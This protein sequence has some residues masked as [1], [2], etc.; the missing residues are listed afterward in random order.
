MRKVACMVHAGV[1][2]PDLRSLLGSLL[3]VVTSSR[4]SALARVFLA[5]LAFGL[6]GPLCPGVISGSVCCSCA[7]LFLHKGVGQ[8]LAPCVFIVSALVQLRAQGAQSVDGRRCFGIFDAAR[9]L[10]RRV[11]HLGGSIAASLFESATPPTFC[12]NTLYGS[13]P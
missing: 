2:A 10:T 3:F 1:K 9:P 5:R 13:S 8:S 6:V 7:Q 12:A 4:G 11:A